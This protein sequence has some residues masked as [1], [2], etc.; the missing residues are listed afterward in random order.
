MALL[1]ASHSCWD[2]S[3]PLEILLSAAI[4]AAWQG[5]WSRLFHIHDAIRSKVEA[6]DSRAALVEA[7]IRRFIETNWPRP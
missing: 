2:T 5:E 6:G 3:Q 7:S 1:C 4:L